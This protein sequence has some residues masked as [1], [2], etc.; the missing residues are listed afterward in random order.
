MKRCSD[1]IGPGSLRVCLRV[2]ARL[3]PGWSS[4]FED[5]TVTALESGG[6]RIDGVL[7]DQA[8]LHGLLSRIRD[9]GIPLVGVEVTDVVGGS[10]SDQASVR[11]SDVSGRHHPRS[12]DHPT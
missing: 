3:D 12:G 6:T 1:D 7:A 5:L 10:A 11:E 4:W 9:L 8:A 2:A